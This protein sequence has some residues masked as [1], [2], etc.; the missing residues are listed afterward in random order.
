M[1]LKT[2]T[3]SP[4]TDSSVLVTKSMV[5][6]ASVVLQ[7]IPRRVTAEP[8]LLLTCPPLNALVPVKFVGFN[9]VTSGAEF[10]TTLVS[11]VKVVPTLL[12][13]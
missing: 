12:L 7:Q 4:D 2:P 8:P 13:A 6:N 5:G 11:L 1:L 3:P 9:V 10:V